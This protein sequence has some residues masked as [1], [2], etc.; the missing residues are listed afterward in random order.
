MSPVRAVI[1]LRIS[2][3]RFEGFEDGSA[4]ARPK[5]EAVGLAE[6][7][8]WQVTE[9]YTDND[10]GAFK[11][12]G[13]R[14]AYDQMSQDFEAGKFDAILCAD[15]DRLTRQPRQL[16]DW[17]DASEDRGLSLITLN[18]GAD[19]STD[20]GR[21]F[22]RV[23]AA[24][25][26]GEV[27]RKS[28]RHRSKNR[29]LVSQ[30]KPV[31]GRRRYGY[32]RG[33]IT[34]DPYE[35][36]VVRR[37]FESIANGATVYGLAKAFNAEGIPVP[38]RMDGKGV[39]RHWTPRR[40]RE[41][42]ANPAYAGAVTHTV[43]GVTTV[44][45]SKLVDAI[46]SPALAQQVR[47]ILADPLRRTSPDDKIKHQLS[48]LAICGVCR[49]SMLFMRAYRCRADASHH[50]A[51]KKILEPLVR[52]EILSALLSGPAA[53]LPTTDDGVSLS[54]I[55]A[56]LT[57]IQARQ[58][59]TLD[60]VRAGNTDAST[61]RHHL[62]AIKAQEAD[63][64]RQRDNIAR[65]SV[66]AEVLLGSRSGLYTGGT[67]RLA[68]AAAQRLALAERFDSLTLERQR[69]LIRFL[70]EITVDRG[71]GPGRVSVHHKVV[72]GLNA[73]SV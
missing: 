35:S 73:V 22:A 37:A 47:D 63:L 2:D 43:D 11:K 28:E 61:E 10:V 12:L 31:P 66:A 60:L 50:S 9:V 25:A 70:L 57:A 44:T 55:Q 42:C 67:V 16:E 21:M 7:K 56:A 27:E 24:I 53:I 8:G 46:V 13:K 29:Q 48:G 1:Y 51:E 34:I 68:D 30:G 41:M 64:I 20:G 3:D 32:L 39:D 23:K 15:L 52:S 17:I 4:V 59:G 38:K 71:R 5:V 14:P 26:R 65:T 49:A 62:L 72:V 45:L 18:G 69:S 54:S 19:L 58:E 40:V 33:N 36:V 6:S